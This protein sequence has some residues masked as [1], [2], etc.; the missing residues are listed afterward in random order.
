MKRFE[1]WAADIKPTAGSETHKNR[2][3]VIISR[4]ALNNALPWVTIAPLTHSVKGYPCRVPTDFQNNN[5]EIVLDQLRCVD[6]NR[7]KKLLGVLDAEESEAICQVLAI[8]F[9]Y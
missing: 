9:D 7:L 3:C 1:V 2:P 8:M 5:G 6:K 4:D